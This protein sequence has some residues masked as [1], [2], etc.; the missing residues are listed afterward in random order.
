MGRPKV[1]WQTKPTPSWRVSRKIG[2]QSLRRSLAFGCEADI[3]GVFRVER[4]PGAVLLRTFLLS[5]LRLAVGWGVYPRYIGFLGVC[6][7]VLLRVS[8]GWHFYTEGVDKYSAGDWDAK[9]F[10]SNARGPFASHYRDLVWDWDGSIRLNPKYAE[11]SFKAFR[12]Q[13]AQ[14]YG[15]DDGQKRQAIAICD[16]ATAQIEEILDAN[17][18]EILEYELGR[19]RIRSLEND[20]MRDGVASLGGQRDAIRAEWLK[21][22]APTLKQID[23]VWKTYESAQ[24]SVAT[25][26]QAAAERPLQMVLPRTK[27]IDTSIINKIVPYF[28][29]AIGVCLLLG[30]F[31]PVA[32]L[33]AAGFLGSVFLS[34]YP[35]TTGPTSTMYQLIEGIACLTLAA[36]GAGRF[37]GLDFLTHSIIRKLWPRV[38]E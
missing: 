6:M 25:L 37:A 11:E 24:N 15:F 35:P 29:M 18:Q 3:I 34:Q 17:K 31:T 38:E 27:P 26:D 12:N 28:D 23:S 14:H 30:L 33:A 16:N 19:E 20:P 2:Q 4:V 1:T 10:F 8:I 9:P 7:L 36:T 13:V 21:G 32:A 22:I 5:P